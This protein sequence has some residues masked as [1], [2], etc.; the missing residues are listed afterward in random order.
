MDYFLKKK[1]IKKWQCSIPQKIFP[2]H[3]QF[4]FL[5]I[6]VSIINKQPQWLSL[7]INNKSLECKSK[8]LSV[9]SGGWRRVEGERGQLLTATQSGS[10]TGN[11]IRALQLL[12]FAQICQLQNSA[13]ENT[14]YFISLIISLKDVHISC[15]IIYLE[16]HCFEIYLLKF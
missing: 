1:L 16:E 13:Q 4:C 10:L 9:Q 7:Y 6:L 8:T 5:S 11:S 15:N 2:H 3:T 14:V 12:H